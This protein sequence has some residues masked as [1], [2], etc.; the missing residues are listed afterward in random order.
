MRGMNDAPR[1]LGRL[2]RHD[3]RS[4]AFPARTKS[5]RTVTHRR[6]AP[7]LDQGDVGS[8]TGNAMA[9]ALACKPLA[10]KGTKVNE[11]LALKLYSRA[12]RLDRFLGVYPP[13]DSGS[14]G[15]AVAKAA[16]EFGYITG[17][18]HAFGLD[19]ALGALSKGPLLIGIPWYSS[20]DHPDDAGLVTIDADAQV[21]GG[22][23]VVLRHLNLDRGLV[24]GDNSWGR[25]WGASGPEGLGGWFTMTFLTLDRLLSEQGDATQLWRNAK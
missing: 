12:T 11:A 5:L 15:L 18:G 22:H 6:T 24:G 16:K 1:P 13:T 3:P 23:E 19:H 21:R 17:Y 14:S 9:G 4:R 2:V 25:A 20:L 7:I 8:C 10:G